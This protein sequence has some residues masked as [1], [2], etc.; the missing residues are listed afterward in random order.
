MPGRLKNQ[1]DA[2]VVEVLGG[3]GLLLVLGIRTDEDR[4]VLPAFELGDTFGAKGR[5]RC[6]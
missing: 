1:G 6:R 5:H 3:M 4:L 2:F